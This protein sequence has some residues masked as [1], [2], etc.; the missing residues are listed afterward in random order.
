[1]KLILLFSNKGQ[2]P[3]L[4]GQTLQYFIK[5]ISL[6]IKK[7]YL[8]KPP[9]K[10][11]EI[12]LQPIL[13][14]LLRVKLTDQKTVG[15]HMILSRLGIKLIDEEHARI[16]YETGLKRYLFD[17]DKKIELSNFLKFLEEKFNRPPNLPQLV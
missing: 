16:D 12:S 17:S 1:M 7:N 3:Y 6:N 9:I 5:F 10:H 11:F 14:E 4:T 8:S 15:F 2:R 13:E